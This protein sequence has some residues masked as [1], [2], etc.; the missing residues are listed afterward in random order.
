MATCVSIL[1]AILLARV[2]IF[3]YRETH[4]RT[5]GNYR[6]AAILAAVMVAIAVAALFIMAN[7]WF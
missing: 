6:T 3:F 1:F 4:L 7:R 5:K 2:N